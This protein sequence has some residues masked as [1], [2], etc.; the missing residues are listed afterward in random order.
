MLSRVLSASEVIAMYSSFMLL[1]AWTNNWSR[2]IL[3]SFLSENTWLLNSIRIIL[4]SYN[5]QDHMFC[6]TVG[7]T[8][9][10]D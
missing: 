2:S 7:E 3:L 10:S 5:T 9:L 6:A 4:V 1:Q 8:H